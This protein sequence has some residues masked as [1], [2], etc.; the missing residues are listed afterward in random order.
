MKSSQFKNLIKLLL[1]PATCSLFLSCKKN[2]DAIASVMGPT[3][4]TL[5]LS[6][7]V[8][9]GGLGPI[10]SRLQD[11]GDSSGGGPSVLCRDSNS[12]LQSARL[13]DVYEGEAL[14]A[15]VYSPTTAS[16]QDQI[17]AVSDRLGQVNI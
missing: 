1:I 17:K 7:I 10:T 8:S 4:A 2:E 16:L 13:L 14:H 3:F 6:N 11:G 5:P 12:V 15:L 9:N